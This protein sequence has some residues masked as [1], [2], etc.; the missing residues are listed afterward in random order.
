MIALLLT[1]GCVDGSEST[2]QGE[3][4]SESGLD[5]EDPAYARLDE[6][7]GFDPIITAAHMFA[8]YGWMGD[9]FPAVLGELSDGAVCEGVTECLFEPPDPGTYLLALTGDLFLCVWQEAELPEVD[10][11]A[12]TD[13]TWEG[14]G[15]C[16]LAPEGTYGDWEVKTDIDDDIGYDQIWINIGGWDAPTTNDSFYSEGED[17]LFE[18]TIASDLSSITY[19]MVKEGNE[20][21]ATITLQ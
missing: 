7:D 15:Q 11:A 9:F 17:S 14:E 21:T 6:C 16:G 1:F 2:C 19:R 12:T 3:Y 8:P 5:C 10:A 4:C 18:G 13:F 20:E